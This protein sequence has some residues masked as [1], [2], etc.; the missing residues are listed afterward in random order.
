MHLLYGVITTILYPVLTLI[1]FI[2]K[3]LKKEDKLR[4]KEKIFHSHFNIN[5]SKNLKLI[6]FHAASVGELKSILPLI[7]EINKTKK[8]IEFLITTV[9]LSSSILAKEKL[10]K[11]K[12]AHHRFFPLD[13][14]SLMKKFIQM[15]KPNII[16]LVDSEIWPNL[17]FLAKKNKIPLALINAR[18]TYKTYKKWMTI[19]NTAK[20]LFNCFDLC[21][22][23]NLESK[24][25]LTQLNAKNIFFNGNIKLINKI[26][27]YK[28]I[29]KNKEFLSKNIFWLAAST[30]KGE[31]IFCLNTHIDLKK[32]INKIITFIAPRHIERVDK[33][34]KLC[35]N[36]KLTYQVLNNFD[37]IQDGNE[38]IIINFY[39]ALSSYY[40]YSKSVFIGKS[41]NKKLKDEGGQSP[42]EA[43]YLGCKIYHG[44]YIYN[45][46]EIYELLES[47]KI[48][49]LIKHKDE[50]VESLYQDLNSVKKDSFQTSEIMMRLGDKTL[51]DT[52]KKINSFLHNENI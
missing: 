45:F 19:S 25:Y 16:F 50:L 46:K 52:M 10:N 41:L 43:A 1:I 3:F 27:D 4:Y 47:N 18:I 28:M 42:I 36:L 30:H 14:Y 9:T 15:W 2:R 39:G 11:I 37:T 35:K 17:I 51:V 32:K 26:E 49:K 8:N 5:R 7:D 12:N 44:G 48:S 13:T 29:D 20:N 21:L 22:T 34:E 31:E 6:W 38:I 40:K 33:I 24:N 23:S